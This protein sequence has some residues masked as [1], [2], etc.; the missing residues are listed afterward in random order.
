MS[1]TIPQEGKILLKNVSWQEFED[2]LVEMGNNRP[3]RIAYDRGNLE[4][5][6]PLPEHEYFKDIISDLIKDLA[7]ELDLDYECLGSTTWKRFDQLAGVEPD[8]CFYIQSESLIRSKL[9]NID[10]DCAPPPDLALEIDITSKSIDRQPIYARLRVPEIWRYDQ[11]IIQI[12]HLQAGEYKVAS[13]SLA[14]PKFPVEEIP[15]FIQQNM[16]LGRRAL[17]KAFRAWVKNLFA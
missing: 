11:G 16:N 2:I 13:S 17:R 8:N 10:L 5:V 1:L 14:F 15:D 4:I 3:T 6:M 9:P 7:E 12:Y